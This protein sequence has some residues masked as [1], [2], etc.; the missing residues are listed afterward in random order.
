MNESSSSIVWDARPAQTALAAAIAF[1]I[2]KI[3]T[4]NMT[5]K[6]PAKMKPCW[7]SVVPSA[8]LAIPAVRM[9]AAAA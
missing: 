6:P 4:T 1:L 7:S 2:P 8:A 3:H 5:T 9:T